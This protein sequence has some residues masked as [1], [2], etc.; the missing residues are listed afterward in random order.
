MFC[1]SDDV[2][3]GSELFNW[4]CGIDIG[5]SIKLYRYCGIDIGVLIIG[6]LIIDV[7]DRLSV[8]KKIGNL[9]RYRGRRTY[10]QISIYYWYI[11]KFKYDIADISCITYR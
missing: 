2:R 10:R 4:Y 7:T 11:D 3:D 5:I 9:C 8:V 6:I 1:D